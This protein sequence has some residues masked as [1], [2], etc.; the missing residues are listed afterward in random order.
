M[1]APAYPLRTRIPTDRALFCGLVP[2]D[3][4]VDRA[5]G[6]TTSRSKLEVLRKVLRRGDTLIVKSP[7]SLARNT[8][9]LLT[10]P[11]E[12]RDEG[13]DL[14]FLATPALSVDS[15]SGE[16]MLTIFSV[17]AQ[18]ER[19]M[20]C[21]RYAEGIAMARERGK[22]KRGPKITPEQLKEARALI[23]SGVSRSRV[24][25]DLHVSLMPLYHALDGGVTVTHWL[26]VSDDCRQVHPGRL[27][28]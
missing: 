28:D 20:I 8:I 12:L 21:E 15:A 4:Y 25:K 14:V 1:G 17:L 11:H 24:A 27:G 22:Y 2:D 23:E 13:V 5:S 10:L 9:D 19:S 16:F 3:A 18:M 7:D 6:G 26:P